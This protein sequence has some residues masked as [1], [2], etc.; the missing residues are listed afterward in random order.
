MKK[1][2]LGLSIGSA[3]A[4]AFGASAQMISKFQQATVS[5]NGIL[6]IVDTTPRTTVIGSYRSILAHISY[7]QRIIASSTEEMKLYQSYLEQ[8]PQPISAPVKA[9]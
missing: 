4:V 8:V 1:F 5:D 6:T 3:L 7:L 9:K 2:I